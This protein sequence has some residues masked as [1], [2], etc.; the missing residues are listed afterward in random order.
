MTASIDKTAK[1]YGLGEDGSWTEKATIRHDKGVR[2]ATFSAD[3][4]HVVTASEDDT[5]KIYGWGEDGSWTEK[6]TIRHDAEVRSA[7]FSADGRHVVT[8][9]NDNTAKICCL[10]LE[11]DLSPP[12]KKARKVRR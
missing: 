11:D 4:R 12:Y 10:Y 3:G 2:S 9:S 6:A 5:T 7:T 8:T 1:I